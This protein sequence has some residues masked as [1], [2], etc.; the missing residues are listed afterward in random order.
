MDVE[1]GDILYGTVVLFV[2]IAA[3]RLGRSRTTALL[4]KVVV[5]GL[6]LAYLNDF[7]HRFGWR[8]D[9]AHDWLWRLAAPD[10]ALI[11]GLAAAVALTVRDRYA[12][13]VS[14]AGYIV[15]RLRSSAEADIQ[16]QYRKAEADIRRQERE[17]R[18]RL[19]AEECAAHARIESELQAARATIQRE[20]EEA[21]K[22]K[23]RASR[24]DPYKVLGVAPGASR[25]AIK[26]RYRELVTA[27]HPD[28]AANTTPEIR[29]LAEEKMKEINGAYE[30]LLKLFAPQ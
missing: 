3:Y 14:E 24:P 28:K 27:Y 4:V 1:S 15:R 16:R 19:E 12:P 22:E 6:G 25:E 29:R 13:M 20:R 23:E 18:E 10:R 9:A 17:A 7:H 2:G 30:K 21:V 5:A 8:F 11:A 26:R